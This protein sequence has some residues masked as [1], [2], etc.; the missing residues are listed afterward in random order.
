MKD[1]ALLIVESDSPIKSSFEKL[2]DAPNKYYTIVKNNSAVGELVTEESDD[3]FTIIWINVYPLYE[4]LGIAHFVLSY[5]ID[6]CKTNG[7]KTIKLDVPESAK[8]ARHIYEKFGFVYDS[9]SDEYLDFGDYEVYFPMSK[10]LE[11]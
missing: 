11:Y 4:N 5:I 7:I 10:R 3:K 9:V 6:H 2:F 8:N 1:N